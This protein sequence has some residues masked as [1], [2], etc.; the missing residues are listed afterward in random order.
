MLFKKLPVLIVVNL[1]V[2]SIAAMALMLM[3]NMYK[4]E[5]AI[6]QVVNDRFYFL[7][8]GVRSSLETEMSLSGV[9]LARLTTGTQQLLAAK[10]QDDAILSIEVFDHNGQTVL[11]TEPS[12]VGDIIPTSWEEAWK[13]HKHSGWS[14]AE[15]RGAKV[16]GLGITDTLGNP[17]GSIVLRYSPEKQTALVSTV[18]Q[19]LIHDGIWI[20][21]GGFAAMAALV[22]FVTYPISSYLN[23]LSTHLSKLLEQAGPQQAPTLQEPSIAAAAATDTDD[24][25]FAKGYCKAHDTINQA[26]AELRKI[27]GE[28]GL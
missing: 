10:G 1:L 6:D 17:A 15:A 26:E 19:D 16:L 5:K 25:G 21:G 22:F 12:F 4:F 18:N 3:I 14:V 9:L 2:V 7:M 24:F 27:D 13:T 20:W 23:G 8:E 28:I 11:S